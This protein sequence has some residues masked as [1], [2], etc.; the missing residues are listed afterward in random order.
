MIEYRYPRPALATDIAVFALDAGRLNVLT[1]RRGSEPYSGKLALPGGFIQVDKETVEQCAERELQEET[2]VGRAPLIQ[3]GI[4]SEPKRDP[5][6]HVVSVAYLACVRMDEASPMGS[7]DAA[8]AQWSVVSELLER[9]AKR[10]IMAFDHD[11]ILCDGVLALARS[12]EAK[13]LV[14][15][16]LPRKFTLSQLQEATEIVLENA[17]LAGMPNAQTALD[18]RNFRRRLA[19]TGWLTETEEM[20]SGA[21]RPARLYMLAETPS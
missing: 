19:E 4:Y 2:G 7:S 20:S 12:L 21:H 5:R 18:K 15:S 14:A 1:I 8:S 11:K 16:M 17:A 10:R 3:F 9:S 6:E 13:P